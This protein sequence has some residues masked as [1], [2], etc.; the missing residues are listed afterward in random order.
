[1]A[2]SDDD[3]VDMELQEL[4]SRPG[5]FNSVP[6]QP[7]GKSKLQKR[8]ARADNGSSTADKTTSSR[9]GT[10]ERLDEDPKEEDTPVDRVA[11]E[12]HANEVALRTAVRQY[13]EAL[14][15]VGSVDRQWAMAV[16]LL[17]LTV[18]IALGAAF[19]AAIN[20]AAWFV[21][22]PIYISVIATF[23][24]IVLSLQPFRIA[25]WAADTIVFLVPLA[26]ATWEVGYGIVYLGSSIQCQRGDTAYCDT[27]YSYDQ[28]GAAAI[29]DLVAGVLMAIAAVG[30]LSASTESREIHK[31]SKALALQT[32]QAVGNMREEYGR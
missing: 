19:F 28:I 24:A 9:T 22:L 20:W 4:V 29:V 16:F 32:R 2:D 3:T 23:M 8:R 5:E 13:F 17:F 15:V 26:F 18:G 27:E 25:H 6:M 30:M 21:L 7:M 10:F 1:M 31:Q 11:L 14:Q 12:R